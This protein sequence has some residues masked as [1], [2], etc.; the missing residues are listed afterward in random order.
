MLDRLPAK[1]AALF[2]SLAPYS[3]GGFFVKGAEAARTMLWR[4]E[5]SAI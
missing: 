5:K 1:L 3:L 4:A 2:V